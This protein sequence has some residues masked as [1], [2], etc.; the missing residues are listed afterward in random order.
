MTSVKLIP[1]GIP[2]IN[3]SN[4]SLIIA[5]VV[6]STRIENKNVHIGSTIFHSGY[7]RMCVCKFIPETKTG[8]TLLTL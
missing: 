2:S 1:F 3:T 4:V 6:A 5:N 8:K 7:K